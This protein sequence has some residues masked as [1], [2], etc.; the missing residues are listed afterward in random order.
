VLHAPLLLHY[1]IPQ[2]LNLLGV[3]PDLLRDEICHALS[4][5][6]SDLSNY[7]LKLWLQ[8]QEYVHNSVELSH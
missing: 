2:E 3:A 7:L 8:A 5:A 1:A 6:A 4:H